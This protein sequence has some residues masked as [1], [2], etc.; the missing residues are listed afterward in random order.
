MYSTNMQP[1]CVLTVRSYSVLYNY[2]IMHRLIQSN[3]Q[4]KKIL[5]VYFKKH[6]ALNFSF[7]YL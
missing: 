3:N 6:S 1:V 2:H 4:M 7:T 5:I